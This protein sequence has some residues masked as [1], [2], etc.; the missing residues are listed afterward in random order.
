MATLYITELVDLG[1]VGRNGKMDIQAEVMPANAVQQVAITASSIQSAAF[2]QGTQCI[3]LYA[4]TSCGFTFGTN[5][6]ASAA[7]SARLATGG[8]RYFVVPLN[9]SYKVAAIQ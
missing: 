5:P 7:T 8:T 4:D 3:H 6:N 9:A 1:Y 2:A